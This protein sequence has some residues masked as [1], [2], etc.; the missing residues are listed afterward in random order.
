MRLMQKFKAK[1]GDGRDVWEVAKWIKAITKMI[2]RIQQESKMRKGW[3]RFKSL[4]HDGKEDKD[5][6]PVEGAA[7][8]KSYIAQFKDIRS[9]ADKIESSVDENALLR[10]VQVEDDPEMAEGIEA[11]GDALVADAEAGLSS[12]SG[13]KSIETNREVKERE[14]IERE[15]LMWWIKPT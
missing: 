10:G 12:G 9:L 4:T 13:K 5:A 7:R 8:L 2:D 6:K 3:P 11:A 1:R 15:N 14:R